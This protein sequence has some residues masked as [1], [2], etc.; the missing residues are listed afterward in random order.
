M[1]A[2]PSI[3]PSS[4]LTSMSCAPPRTWSRATSTA[5]ARSPALT[6][7]AKRRDP[8]TFVRSPTLTRL[9]SGRITRG[10]RPANRGCGSGAGGTRGAT[11]ATA[12]ANAATCS[13]VVPQQPP[14]TLTQPSSTN[15]RS[16]A[17]ISDG[18]LV[19]AAE[20]VREAGVRVDDRERRREAGEF[21]DVRAQL[22]GSQR[23]V[24]ADREQVGVGDRGPERLERL[25]GERAPRSVGDRAGDHER[26]AAA[27]RRHRGLARDERRFGDERVEDRL[28]QEQVDAPLEQG[29]RLLDVPGEDL[30]EGHVAVAGVL[31]AR[32]EA[33]RLVRR[34]HGARDPAR[35]LGRR[36]R[37]G[38]GAREPRRR[39]V[40]LA[41]DVAEPVLGEARGGWR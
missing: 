32:R 15:S 17:T 2:G 4:T 20:G 21:L 16:T 13:G 1:V 3:M 25:P 24:E 36:R 33:E 34:P 18:P 6:S 39:D 5:A 14:S 26:H 12:A 29:G 22:L 35:A 40:Q 31:D 11:P 30:V 37:V 27:D 23:A 10:S 41:H 8:V 38:G 9:V 7:R 28:D 19:V